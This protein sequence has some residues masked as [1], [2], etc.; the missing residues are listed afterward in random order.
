MGTCVITDKKDLRTYSHCQ[1]SQLQPISD[2]FC[3]Y[4]GTEEMTSDEAADE[5]QLRFGQSASLLKITSEQDKEDIYNSLP[6]SFRGKKIWMGVSRRYENE[7]FIWDD[8]S[9]VV[10]YENWHGNSGSQDSGERI[11]GYVHANGNM[12]WKTDPCDTDHKFMCRVPALV[13][14]TDPVDI[15]T[16]SPECP[17][18]TFAGIRPS[19]TQCGVVYYDQHEQQLLEYVSSR[20]CYLNIKGEVGL[21]ELRNWTTLGSALAPS[22]TGELMAV[23]EYLNVI[24]TLINETSADFDPDRFAEESFGLTDNILHERNGELW[25]NFQDDRGISRLLIASEK[26][27]D[28]LAKTAGIDTEYSGDNIDVVVEIGFSENFEG[29]TLNDN[30]TSNLASID[31]DVFST[32]EPSTVTIIGVNYKS[33]D[34]LAK[35]N[36][37]EVVDGENRSDTV[38]TQLNSGIVSLRVM[39]DGAYTSVPVTCILSHWKVLCKII[40]IVLHFLYLSVFTW[41]FVEGLHLYLQIVVVFASERNRVALYYIIGWGV[42]GVIVAVSLAVALDG[43]G[44]TM[45][46]CW[47]SVKTGLIWAFVGPAI[48]VIFSNL[49]VLLVV[50]K[51]VI[52]SKGKDKDGK[53]DHIK[54]AAKGALILLPLLGLS[55]AFGLM[56]VNKGLI[57]F[58]YLFAIF[59]SLQGFFIFLLHGVLSTEVRA[60]LRR[61]REKHAFARG[62]MSATTKGW[63]TWNKSNSKTQPAE[64]QSPGL[65]EINNSDVSVVQQIQIVQIEGGKIDG[66]SEND[67]VSRNDV[68]VIVRQKSGS[69]SSRATPMVALVPPSPACSP[70]LVQDSYEGLVEDDDIETLRT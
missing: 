66:Q 11:C 26:T 39:L 13:E 1:D 33:L 49:V 16:S 40:S 18:I 59:N 8:G 21:D 47:L 31:A 9:P 46:H 20:Y 55:W 38:K 44:A 24:A 10:G 48:F 63:S 42:P 57:V 4:H 41:M 3:V 54:A 15:T 23:L 29:F 32:D 51:I 30:A 65:I 53:Y 7:T 45:G 6:V 52:K 5:C 37:S 50:L 2:S 28:I 27:T 43:Y 14:G 64:S 19:C 68:K 25:N 34:K 69:G 35:K 22:T 56:S 17:I 70:F 62:E 58:Q 60:A 67:G 36:N 12:D 61:T